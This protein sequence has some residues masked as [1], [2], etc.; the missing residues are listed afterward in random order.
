MNDYIIIKK[1]KK[2]KNN[3]AEDAGGA[4]K[5][6]L[7]DFMVAMM[8]IFF[9]LWAIAMQ[10]PEDKEKL[11]AILKGEEKIQIDK[12]NITKE[13]HQKI[14]ESNNED[15]VDIDYN[16]K[17]NF[18]SIKLDSEALFESGSD[19]L[20]SDAKQVITKLSKEIDDNKFYIHVY[21]YTDNT[22]IR[23]SSKI[24]NN[25]E[26]SIERAISAGMVLIQGGFNGDRITLHGEGPLNPIA[27][28]SSAGNKKENRRVEIYITENSI[29]FKEY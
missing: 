17:H 3:S 26:L 5:I 1:N 29:P 6:A 20:T 9:A 13:L 18:I 11:V 16:S 23:S 12:I 4:W 25:L 21:G 27:E 19:T 15:G 2:N 7:A 10:D 8:I 28:N 24:L 14:L 22:P